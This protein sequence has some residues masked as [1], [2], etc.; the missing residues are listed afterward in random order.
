M[1]KGREFGIPMDFPIQLW[2]KALPL[3]PVYDCATH[4][5]QYHV[6]LNS[7]PHIHLAF[8]DDMYEGA[9]GK[10]KYC[11]RKNSTEDTYTTALVKQPK[12]EHDLLLSEALVQ[13]CVYSYFAS[14]GLSNHIPKVYDI[15]FYMKDTSRTACKQVWFTMEKKE[16]DTI[17]DWLLKIE[18][19]EL[20]FVYVL[21]QLCILLDSLHAC[22][23]DHRD[24]KASN[25]LVCPTPC[26]IQ[27]GTRIKSFPITLVL[28][29][30]G[31]SCVGELDISK[32]AFPALD[33]CPK[34]GRDMFHL[35]A[36][37][38]SY[39]Q[40]RE[41]LSPVWEDWFKTRLTVQSKDYSRLAEGAETNNWIYLLS[42]KESLRVPLCSPIRI[43]ADL[44]ADEWL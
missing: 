31:F 32:G 15:F 43:L 26:E 39:A 42:G 6:S 10:L 18:T 20:V 38:W 40:L 9:F 27:I 34:E 24:L 19:P 23:V 16:G 44:C 11:L 28:I 3:L 36:D 25:I 41:K 8:G 33:P 30:F 4:E 1:L 37:L 14:I 17:I 35:L 29:D 12:V 5:L 7:P 2:R 21:A 22:G 13:H